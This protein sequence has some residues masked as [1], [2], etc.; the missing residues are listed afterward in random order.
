MSLPLQ[1]KSLAVEPHSSLPHNCPPKSFVYPITHRRVPRKYKK[2]SAAKASLTDT[3][4]SLEIIQESMSGGPHPRGRAGAFHG[5]WLACA[6]TSW[7]WLLVCGDA[8]PLG[9]P[10]GRGH[11]R[12]G[13]TCTCIFSPVSCPGGRE[14]EILQHKFK[15]NKHNKTK[16]RWKDNN[17]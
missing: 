5:F 11:P 14:L 4:L 3:L 17:S 2:D 7:T 13:S 12:V 16:L 6:W 15:A 8:P 1:N 9:P 10:A